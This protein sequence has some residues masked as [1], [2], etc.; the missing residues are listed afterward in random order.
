MN[1]KVGRETKHIYLKLAVWHILARFMR[2]T[3][4]HNG[5]NRVMSY[6]YKH[7]EGS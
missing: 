4:D 3:I 2:G 6:P 5:A 7:E 1:Y